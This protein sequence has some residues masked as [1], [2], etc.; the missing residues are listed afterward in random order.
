[1]FIKSKI[2]RIICSLV[3]IGFF[4]P[5][6]FVDARRSY[7]DKHN[8]DSKFG[9]DFSLELVGTGAVILSWVLLI[10]IVNKY[11][12]KDE[13]FLEEQN[14]KNEFK[15]GSKVTERT[16]FKDIIGLDEILPEVKEYVDFLKDPTKYTKMG[17]KKPKGLLLLGPPGTGKTLLAR[18]IAGEAGCS[19][20]SVSG[21][22]FVNMY[23]GTGPASVRKLFEKARQSA[24]TI[25][26]IDEID[27][28]SSR[29]TGDGGGGR[30]YDNTINEFL[31]QMDGFDKSQKMKDI[32]VIGATNFPERLDKA[33]LRPGRFDRKVE[34]KLPSIKGRID[35]LEYYLNKIKFDKKVSIKSVA[36]Q[37][38]KLTEG[39]SPAQ[40]EHIVNEA[41]ILAVRHN[42]LHVRTEHLEE[43][44]I[45]EKQSF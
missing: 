7:F 9:N 33:L 31:K 34:V 8:K 17:A 22:E 3:L 35:I 37:I 23:V 36:K 39:F 30:E 10:Y 21:T 43:A 27:G 16:T 41:A 4:C 26:F 5:F 42:D 45:K 32:L 20:I 13:T 18:A 11:Q 44:L 14:P 1:M 2:K 6:D 24:P 40:L 19:F 29:T 28:L 38:A 12:D 15:N 25:I